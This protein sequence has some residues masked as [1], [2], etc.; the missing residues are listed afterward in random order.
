MYFIPSLLGWDALRSTDQQ[1][2]W[3][4][5]AA[6]TI[7]PKSD[8]RAGFFPGQDARNLGHQLSPP[9]HLLLA[10]ITARTAE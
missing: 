8:A 6:K 3:A 2:D 4:V 7:H 10:F 1:A 5:L 9:A